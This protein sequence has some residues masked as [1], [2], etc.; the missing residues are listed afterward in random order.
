M[1]EASMIRH[2]LFTP[3]EQGL[4]LGAFF[5]IVF[6]FFRL[7]A[8]DLDRRTGAAGI[9]ALLQHENDN[10]ALA[11]RE[12]PPDKHPL[13]LPPRRIHLHWYR[14]AD[15]VAH[16]REGERVYFRIGHRLFSITHSHA[17]SQVLRQHMAGTRISRTKV[18]AVM[19]AVSRIFS[20][21]GVRW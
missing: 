21:K 5:G 17:T 16:I 8:W 18:A 11:L 10:A 20:E 14:Y 6:L 15:R 3:S 4:F 7:V 2:Y 1:A 19:Q 12:H 9:E 13:A